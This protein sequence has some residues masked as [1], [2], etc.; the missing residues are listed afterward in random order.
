MI[1]YW[2]S[3]PFCFLDLVDNFR[4]GDRRPRTASEIWIVLLC[5]V[6]KSLEGIVV[7]FRAEF[8]TQVKAPASAKDTTIA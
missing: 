4:D 1:V 8:F 2:L 3:T 6:F 5:L 7:V